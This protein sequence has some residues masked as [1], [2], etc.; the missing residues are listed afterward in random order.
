A[1]IASKVYLLTKYPNTKETKG[2][3]P[4]GEDILIE[5]VKA[6]SNVE[7]IYSANTKKILGETFVSG[8]VY[9]DTETKQEHEL[10]INGV[11]VHIGM[12]PNSQFVDCVKKNALGEIE[13]DLIGNT[14]CK[15][16]FA[17][18]DVTNIPY[19]QIA[20]AAGQGVTAALSAI[21]YVNRWTPKHGNTETLKHG[22]YV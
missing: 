20:I 1:G 16:V 3:F 17:A 10:N 6:L 19:K 2:G 18:G 21:D 13:I 7:I 8:L 11:M 9:E 15:G 5:K 22:T 12:V 14:S 4:K